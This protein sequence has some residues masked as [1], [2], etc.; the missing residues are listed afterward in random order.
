MSDKPEDHYGPSP[1]AVLW[2]LYRLASEMIG[3]TFPGIDITAL[4]V[5]E[6]A[7]R[8]PSKRELEDE[9]RRQG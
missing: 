9:Q 3:T 7:A 2:P 8:P 6:E 4:V 5:E 1:L